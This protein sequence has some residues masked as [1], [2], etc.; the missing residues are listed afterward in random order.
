[1]YGVGRYNVIAHLSE[2]VVVV[3]VVRSRLLGGVVSISR[4]STTY[5]SA[6]GFETSS[7]IPGKTEF[8]RF[9]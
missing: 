6:T 7:S 9:C 2:V 3:I 1:M 8:L 4:I 5:D